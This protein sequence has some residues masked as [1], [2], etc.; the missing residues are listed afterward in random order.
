[1]N[2]NRSAVVVALMLLT[3]VPN[4]HGACS[5]ESLHGTYGYFSQGFVSVTADISPALFLPQ[6]Q[7]GLVTFDGK[8]NSSG[9]Y[10]INSTDAAGGVGRG[11]FTGTYAINS[12]CTGTAE[13]LIDVGG[14]VHVDTVVLSPTEFVSINTDAGS[15][16][17]YSGKKIRQ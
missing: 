4:L 7:T 13:V 11:T 1:M 14:S 6:A 8:G 17:I 2:A 9:T 15:S 12:D 5:N 16:I 10:T 3:V